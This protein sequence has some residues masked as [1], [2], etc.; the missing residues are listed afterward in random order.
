MFYKHTD[1]AYS[2]G[3]KCMYLTQKGELAYLKPFAFL[4]SLRDN[5]LGSKKKKSPLGID[6]FSE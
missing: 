6:L 5:R 1:M 4:N 2:L 3:L